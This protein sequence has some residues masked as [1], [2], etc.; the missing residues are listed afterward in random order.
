MKVRTGFVSNSSSSSYVIHASEF[1]SKEVFKDVII[2]L[3][4][5]ENSFEGG[6]TW[7]ESGRTFSTDGDY[8]IV[9][10]N[11]TYDAVVEAFAK[12][13]VNF[14]KLNKLYLND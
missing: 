14:K 13:G 11:Y 3:T 7:G 2:N 8:M 9:E 12:A 6:F 5:L 4:L 1:P 10:T